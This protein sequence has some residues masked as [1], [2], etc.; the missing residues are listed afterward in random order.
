LQKVSHK[1]RKEGRKEGRNEGKEDRVKLPQTEDRGE[2]IN[3]GVY[4]EICVDFFNYCGGRAQG[5]YR[6]KLV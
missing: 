3:L 2:E 6:T 4:R 1:G 5:D